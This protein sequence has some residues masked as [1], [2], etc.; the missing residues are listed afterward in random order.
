MPRSTFESPLA[1]NE[2]GYLVAGLDP[3]PASQFRRIGA[4]KL[5]VTYGQYAA[6]WVAEGDA[7]RLVVDDGAT[8]VRTAVTTKRLRP[9]APTL[10][11]D[12]VLALAGHGDLAADVSFAG[13][14]V[15]S[16]TRIPG[17]RYASLAE[18]AGG[19]IAALDTR[20]ERVVLFDRDEAALRPR[21]AFAVTGANELRAACEGRALLVGCDDADAVEVWCVLDDATA[22]A[23]ARFEDIDRLCAFDCA[24]DASGVVF[25]RPSAPMFW[26]GATGYAVVGLDALAARGA[27]LGRFAP[28]PPA[29]LPERPERMA[30]PVLPEVLDAPPAS[31]P[32]PARPDPQ[33]IGSPYVRALVATILRGMARDTAD[34]AVSALIA[35]N[36]PADLAALLGACAW[37]RTPHVSLGEFWL[38]APRA[39]P[40]P[41]AVGDADEAVR[42]GTIANGDEVVVR[43]A[44][45]GA[46]RVIE[47]SHEEDAEIDRG[48][49]DGFLRHCVAYARAHGEAS[50]LDELLPE[51]D[52]DGR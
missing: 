23:V 46:A 25:A 32:V 15:R 2:V 12:G 40:S 51:D 34:P 39:A 18:L 11:N 7:L 49:L 24:T 20:A 5:V 44:R 21:T 52:R 6:A 31:R 36:T 16:F 17:G 8:A 22:R 1:L 9:P 38:D 41:R 35:P 47:L 13:G 42:I 3:P 27:D 43:V 37:H 10:R 29:S 26:T 28:P 48:G 4:A 33:R 19:T 30:A 45:D 14:R 50:S